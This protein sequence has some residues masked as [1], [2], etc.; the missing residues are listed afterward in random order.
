VSAGQAG[1]QGRL[2]VHCQRHVARRAGDDDRR[3]EQHLLPLGIDDRPAR[4]RRPDPV[5]DGNPYGT[6]HTSN[7]GEIPPGENEFA[8]MEFQTRRVVETAATFRRGRDAQFA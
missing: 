1:R 4:L 3:A 6:S 8:A 2:I 5:P 7:N